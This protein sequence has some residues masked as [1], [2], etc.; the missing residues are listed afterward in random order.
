MWACGTGSSSPV[1]TLP[2]TRPGEVR[3]VD[4][5]GGADLVGDLAHL[6]EVHPAGVRRVAGHQHQRLELAGLRG[7]H[8]V[9]E[10]AGL[11]VGAVLLLVEHLAADVGPEAVGEVAAGVQGHAE[12]PLVAELVT[13]RLPVGLG[14][15]VDVPRAQLR[16]R[17]R[18]DPVGEDRPEGDQV[19]VDA[20]VRLGVGVLR[21]EQLAGVLGGERLDGVDVLAAGVEAVADGAL[22]VLVAEPGAHGEQHGGRGVVLACDQLQR[23]ALVG[24]LLAGGVGDPRLD[25]G[26]DLEGLAVGAAGEGG[27]TGVVGHDPQPSSGR[28]AGRP[29]PARVSHRGRLVSL[30]EIPVWWNGCPDRETP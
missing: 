19:G 17:G 14:Q 23:A 11:G 9:V 15:V 26:D 18:L 28:R 16:Q 12:Q 3:H 1:N 4:H 5:E 6:G 10:Q 24:Q 8:V 2:A 20:G 29:P 21:T 30:H 13:Q 27:E 7:D 25:R 22:G